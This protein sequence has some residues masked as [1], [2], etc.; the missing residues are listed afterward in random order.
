VRIVDLELFSD[1]GDEDDQQFRR[2]GRAGVVGG[3]MV[4]PRLLGPILALTRA[5]CPS[6]WLLTEPSN[7]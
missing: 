5:G 2:F 6:S 7:T 1:R 4:G 3:Q